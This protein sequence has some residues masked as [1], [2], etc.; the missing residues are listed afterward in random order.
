MKPAISTDHP[1]LLHGVA[2][3]SLVVALFGTYWDDAWHTDIGRDTFWSPPHILLYAGIALAGA[4][5]GARALRRYL[6]TRSIRGVLATRGLAISIVGVGATMLSAPIDETWHALYGRDAVAWS[7]P[8]LLGLVGVLLLVGGIQLDL[9]Q[10]TG[11]RSAPLRVLADAAVLA[12]LLAL[13]FEYDT[14]VPQFDEVWYLP[15]MTLGM[16]IAFGLA[17]RSHAQGWPAL[18]AAGAYTAL[19]VATIFAL[20]ALGHSHPIV[21]AVIVPALAHDIAARRRATLPVRA[22]ALVLATWIAYPP[23]LDLLDGVRL[24]MVDAPIGVP[25]SLLAAGIGL[26]LTDP[27]TRPRISR[28]AAATLVLVAL[29]PTALAHDPGQGEPVADITLRARQFEDEW[30]VYAS[31]QGLDCDAIEP[32]AAFARRAGETIEGRMQGASPC[33]LNASLALPDAS[34][35]W[36]GYVRFRDAAGILEAWIPLEPADLETTKTTTLYRP[37]EARA[38]AAQVVG[39]IALYS[40]ELALVGF[41]LHRSR[42][43]DAPP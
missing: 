10:A 18:S 34:G 5:I 31:V 16:A 1:L 2:L 32:D 26:A 14:D 25:L 20:L 40:T 22:I 11:P 3:V 6:E 21:P 41:F 19:M 8:H 35:R 17:R 12:T 9:R 37:P 7:P 24:D 15:V 42:R 23:Y 28:A 13:V 4:S 27:P 36:F 43:A 39:S 38:G 29:A 30:V 33:R